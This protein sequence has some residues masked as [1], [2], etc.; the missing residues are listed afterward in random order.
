MC[1]YR[2]KVG[3]VTTRCIKGTNMGRVKGK[4]GEK[5]LAMG[6]V[7]LVWVG[8]KIWLN[9]WIVALGFSPNDSVTRFRDSLVT[10]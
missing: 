1:T 10:E 7:G 4:R 3:K 2:Q 5:V 8:V 6:G 9:L